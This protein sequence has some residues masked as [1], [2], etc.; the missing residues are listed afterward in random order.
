MTTG[1]DCSGL[2]VTT[3]FLSLL[4]PSQ[5]ERR[6]ADGI[7]FILAAV[8]VALVPFAK[9]PLAPAQ[10]FIPAYQSVLLFSDLATAALLFGQFS[11]QRTRGLLV[12]ATAYLFTGLATVPHTLS[13]PG[14][15]A[16]GGVIGA[17][18]QT[19]VWLYMMWHA[20]FPLLMMLYAVVK[21]DDRPLAGSS[22]AGWLAVGAAIATVLAGTILTTQGHTLLPTLL[23]PDNTYTPTMEFVVF[24]V[25]GLNFIS[26]GALLS[27]RAAVVD[28]RR[29]QP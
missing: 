27:L 8:F 3:V 17:G 13:F 1:T 25:W 18:P 16:S 21:G 2:R 10:A 22:H 14:L 11:I 6:L 23:K 26:L 29:A 12:L 5:F 19:T 7:L 9:E 20:G 4:P 24:A 15:L 28:C